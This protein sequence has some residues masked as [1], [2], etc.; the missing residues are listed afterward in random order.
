MG[1]QGA[2]L[3]NETEVLLVRHAYRPGWHFPGGGVEKNET[4]R[5]TLRRE[6]HEEVGV[7]VEGQPTLFGIYANFTAFPSDHVTFFVVHDWQRPTVPEPNWEIAEHAFFPLDAL[8][9]GTT[10]S[11]HRRL[12]E[13]AGR[14]PVGD[15]W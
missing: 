9:D 8:P 12:D 4:V 11:V 6:L 3:K 1:A 2:V 5:D 13:L 7:V 15:T 10:K 14:T